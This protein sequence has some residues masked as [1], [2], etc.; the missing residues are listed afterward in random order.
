MANISLTCKLHTNN[1][2]ISTLAISFLDVIYS[3]V[4][5]ASSIIDANA[6]ILLT[7]VKSSM[8]A[9]ME[10]PHPSFVEMILVRKK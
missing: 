3:V 8:N 1:S 4:C 9:I 6:L 5:R 10:T 7:N 2:A